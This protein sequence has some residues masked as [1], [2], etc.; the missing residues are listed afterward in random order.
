MEKE[1][2]EVKQQILNDLNEYMFKSIEKF[3]D[4]LSEISNEYLVQTKTNELELKD[5]VEKLNNDKNKIQFY[6]DNTTN[7]AAEWKNKEIELSKRE[8]EVK[9]LEASSKEISNTAN[10]LHDKMI[11]EYNE[12][13]KQ[14]DAFHKEKTQFRVK[15]AM[16]DEQMKTLKRLNIK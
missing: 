11:K 15:K 7:K 6:I 16:V 1:I 3:T 4:L 14:Q 9:I 10:L 12:F 2:Q 13:Q 8:H 5:K